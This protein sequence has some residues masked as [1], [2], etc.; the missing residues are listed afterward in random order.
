MVHFYDNTKQHP[1]NNYYYTTKHDISHTSTHTLHTNTICL[2]LIVSLLYFFQTSLIYIVL[3]IYASTHICICY[4]LLQTNASCMYLTS[5][6]NTQQSCIHKY[7]FEYLTTYLCPY[8][9]ICNI[10]KYKYK[11]KYN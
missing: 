10:Y 6:T 5:C 1:N 11:Y 2:I 3:C 7:M 9:H 4:K 8:K